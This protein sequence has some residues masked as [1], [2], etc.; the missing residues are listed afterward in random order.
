M[1]HRTTPPALRRKLLSHAV[2]L[3]LYAS[4]AAVYAQG[5]TATDLGT[6]QAGA[7]GSAQSGQ[8]RKQ[9]APYQALSSNSLKARQPQSTI[10]QH[11]IEETAAPASNYSDIVGISPSVMSIDPNGPG[12]SE[13]GN[14]HV[15]GPTIRGFTDG[16]YD[17]TFDGIPWGDSNDFTHHSTT[18]FMPQDLGPITVERGP[19]DASN[20]GPATFGGTIHVSSKDPS[21]IP[22]ATIY[23]S[24]GSWGTHM[25]GAE[26]DTGLMKNYGD[27]RAFFDYRK[28]DS[29]GY[30]SNTSFHR[31]NLFLKV[32][33]PVGDDS[34][35]T[36]VGM[37]NHTLQHPPF[38]ATTEP[39]VAIPSGNTGDPATAPGVPGQMQAFGSNYGFNTN[40][41]SQADAAYNYD[42]IT[43]D[44][45]YVDLKTH[46]GDWK[47]DNK[48][49]TYAYYHN[50]YAGFAPNDQ[51]CSYGTLDCP[52]GVSDGTV[53]AAVAAAAATN[54]SDGSVYLYQMYM[55][56][57]SWGDLLRTAR[58]FSTGTL[59]TGVWIDRQDNGRYETSTYAGAGQYNSDRL[60][61]DS[62]TQ[63]QPYV[64]YQ[65]KVAPRL[66]LTP[67]LR[68]AYFR[69]TLDAQINQG[70][71]QPAY[72]IAKSWNKL[73]PSIDAHYTVQPGW[74]VYAQAAEGFLAPNLNVFYSTDPLQTA[75][76]V[77]PQTTQNFQLGSSW[78][79]HDLVLSGDI[80]RVNNS[81]AVIGAKLKGNTLTYKYGKAHYQGI[82]AEGTY[83]VGS[84]YSVYAN[85]SYNEAIDDN[86]DATQGEQIA[87]IP[88]HTEALG[89]IYN[90]GPWYGALITKFLGSRYGDFNGATPIYPFS[91]IAITNLAINYTAQG[92]NMLPKG[93]KIGLQ[94]GNLFDN[95]KLFALAGYTANSGVPLFYNNAGRSVTLNLSY[96]FE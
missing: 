84:G 91:A 33:R 43:T 96:P 45:E 19:G 93:A 36:V 17:V 51:A 5:T 3:A 79:S 39:Y 38:G 60:M 70:S 35:L 2:L 11:V 54:N 59:K 44:F 8:A 42:D 10:S 40:P 21:N 72:G 83:Y 18:Y 20:I 25:L 64:E 30:L 37:K 46:M 58:D 67:G 74:V 69:R 56:Y 9:S 52:G 4:P 80:Y 53:P 16:Q 81:N 55:N 27:T 34:L 82:E 15:G 78:R 86:A 57:R 68:D 65:W 77:S 14:N 76:A 66:V 73:L 22:K 89:L 62:L 75:D 88:K 12:L 1:N 85:A 95:Q 90:Q 28:L 6:V 63:L 29:N 92:D 61:K 24:I 87:G 31:S 32:E 7:Q 41:L 71:G 50:G 49:Y 48:V 26:F 13:S 94:I 23:G 47:V